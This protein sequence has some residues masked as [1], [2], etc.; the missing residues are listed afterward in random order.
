MSAIKPTTIRQGIATQL[1]NGGWIQTLSSHEEFPAND[2]R[3]KAHKLFS[4]QVL[5]TEFYLPKTSS[6]LQH[7]ATTLEVKLGWRIR[8]K[9]HREDIDAGIAE[10]QSVLQEVLIPTGA[11]SIQPV[12]LDYRIDASGYWFVG[13]SQYKVNHMYALTA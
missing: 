6:N 1:S 5:D 9:N 4:V 13:T 11:Y 2:S 8:A 12:D 3:P 10:I 7:V